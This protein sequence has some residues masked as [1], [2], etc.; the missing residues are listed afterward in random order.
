MDDKD[1]FAPLKAVRGQK[2]VVALTTIVREGRLLEGAPAWMPTKEAEALIET[3]RARAARAIDCEISGVALTPPG[4][5]L[6][7]TAPKGPAELIETPPPASPGD[8]AEVLEA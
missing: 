2:C 3:G 5:A 1:R 8:V 6:S 7:E 4:A